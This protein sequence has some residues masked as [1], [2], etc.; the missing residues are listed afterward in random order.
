LEPLQQFGSKER[1]PQD[2]KLA[3]QTAQQRHAVAIDERDV[4]EVQLQWPGRLERALATLA[5]LVDPCPTDSPMD[6]NQDA[7][8][9]IFDSLKSQHRAFSLP[10]ES[11]AS[12]IRLK[13]QKR[14]LND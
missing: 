8:V 9:G 10:D 11:K 12:A 13:R 2:D 4:L 3:P 14:A 1:R 6:T 7:A 5:Q